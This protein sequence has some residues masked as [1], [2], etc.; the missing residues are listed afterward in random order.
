M[1]VEAVNTA[2]PA[3]PNESL[4]RTVDSLTLAE[5]VHPFENPTAIFYHCV[6]DACG[7]SVR[8]RFDRSKKKSAIGGKADIL[9]AQHQHRAAR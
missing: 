7:R 5:T 2:I 9:L 4:K 3:T 1:A 6:S 8:C